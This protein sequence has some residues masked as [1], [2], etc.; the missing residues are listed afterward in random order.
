MAAMSISAL[1]S[2]F[3]DALKSISHGEN[4][5]NSKHAASFEYTE[6]VMRGNVHASMMNRTYKTTVSVK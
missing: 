1:A 2:F 6:G 5:N 4:H 3:A